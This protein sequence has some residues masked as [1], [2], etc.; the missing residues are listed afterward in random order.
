VDNAG[1][2]WRIKRHAVSSDVVGFRFSHDKMHLNMFA[3][4]VTSAA[5]QCTINLF[6]YKL[7]TPFPFA[8]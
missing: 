7:L 1:W 8:A 4:Q 3:Q 5:Q 6:F 2:L